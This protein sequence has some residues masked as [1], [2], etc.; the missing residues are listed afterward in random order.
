MQGVGGDRSA[1]QGGCTAAA[2]PAFMAGQVAFG[3]TWQELLAWASLP[4]S[5][6]G[7]CVTRSAGQPSQT[8]MLLHAPASM[9]QNGCKHACM[10]IPPC[11]HI[12][13]FI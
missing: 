6:V 5:V 9:H 13:G 2:V 7:P 10:D 11:Q 3:C 12:Q 1:V 8:Q 4:E